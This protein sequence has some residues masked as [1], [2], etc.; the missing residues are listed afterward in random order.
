[1]NGYGIILFVHLAALL[2]AISTAGIAHFAEERLAAAE[3]V[4]AARLWASLLNRAAPV[5]PLALLVLLA[6]GAYLVHR[7]WTWDSGWIEA[8]LVGVGLLF[9]NGAGVVGRRN[10]ALKR[11]LR[12]AA[13]GP[14]SDALR[15]VTRRHV[16]G[17]ASWV[18]TGLAIGVVFVMTT[19]PGLPGSLAAL[20]VAAA[21]GALAAFR[22][23]RHV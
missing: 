15:Q 9:A 5:F 7:G 6:S 1:V 3:T 18:N 10:L 20:A 12:S 2:A 19:K 4:A 13:D 14:L 17:I 8:A 11:A 21:L 22:L 23:R 16:G